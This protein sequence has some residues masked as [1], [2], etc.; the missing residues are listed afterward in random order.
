MNINLNNLKI[1][2]LKD[3]NIFS[4][5]NLILEVLTNVINKIELFRKQKYA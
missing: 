2:F 5:I 1:Y 3:K 4:C